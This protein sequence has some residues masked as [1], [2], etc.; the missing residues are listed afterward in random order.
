MRAGSRR[1]RCQGQA[2]L[3]VKRG[4]ELWKIEAYRYTLVGAASSTDR[5]DRITGRFG[6]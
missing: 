6:P 2:T 1:R 5:I 4:G 3:V